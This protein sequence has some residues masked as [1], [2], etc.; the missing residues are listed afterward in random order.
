MAK[1]VYPWAAFFLLAHI[2]GDIMQRTPYKVV[3][4]D[5]SLPG[6]DRNKDLFVDTETVGLYGKIRLVQF[7][8]RGM[9]E[10]LIVEWPDPYMLAATMDQFNNVAH[11][12]H[13][14]VT[15][16]QQ[17]SGTRWIP[18]RMVD[19]FLLARLALPNNEAFT[20]D[21]V[22]LVCLGRDPYRMQGLKK[23]DLQKSDWGA[24]KLSDDQY[25]YAATDVYYL[26]NVLDKVQKAEEEFSYKLDMLTLRYCL[27]FQWN[28]MPLSK[29]RLF[30]QWDKAEKALSEI[31]IPVN[32]ASPKQVKEWL[33][34]DSSADLELAYIELN[35]SETDLCYYGSNSEGTPKNIAAGLIRKARKLKKR[36]SFLAKF[37]ETAKDG[38]IYGKFKPSARS[39]RLTSDDQNLQQLPRSLKEVFGVEPDSGLIL[40][41]ADYAQIELRHICALVECKL[42]EELFRKGED[43]HTYT[44]DMIFGSFESLFGPAFKAAIETHT[45]RNEYGVI[46]E[47]DYQRI[48]DGVE[49]EVKALYKR[50]RQIS[51]TCNFSLLYGGGVP[52]FISILVKTTNIWLSERDGNK[53]RAKW[54]NLWKEIYAWQERGIA[55]WRKGRLGSTPLGRKYSSKMMTDQ[56]NIEN[57]GGAADVNKLAM[58]YLTPRLRDYNAEH[59]T[60]YRIANNIHDSYILI[61]ESIP[62]HYQAVARILAEEMQRAWFECSKCLKIKDLPMPVDVKCGYNWG[63]I[64]NDDIENVYDFTLEPYAML[65]AE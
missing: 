19:T 49:H 65:E 46:S 47:E 30:E 35:E 58:H 50:N 28:G 16:V 1:A 9:D 48:H 13:Y 6:F 18:E 41:Y 24:P 20:L 11:N 15:V 22:M 53:A 52:M 60:T 7:Y 56:L 29:A 31:K 4:K 42:M 36:L 44:A 38:F 5:L 64:E 8:Q 10:V 2:N 12:I 17:N 25:V 26:P 34:I 63:D 39:G 45:A 61:G 54:R 3:L 62:E 27:D 37:E 43:L 51:K 14:E 23:A 40:V 32:A 55:A 33:G 57:Q 21:D 59:G